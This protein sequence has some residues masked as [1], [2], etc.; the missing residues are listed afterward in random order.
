MRLN[1]RLWLH[2][3]AMACLAALPAKTPAKA[4]AADAAP[5][6]TTRLLR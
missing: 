1:V 3:A 6:G 5:E 4:A 2:L